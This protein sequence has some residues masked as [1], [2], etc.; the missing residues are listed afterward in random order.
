MKEKLKKISTV[1]KTIFG[2]SMMITLLVGALTFFGYL[3]ALIIGGDIAALICD[4]IYKKVIPA[5]IYI[6]TSTVLFGLLA[7]Y[8]AGEKALTPSNKSKYKK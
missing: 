3:V 2:Y 8:L 1:C 5:M 6:N 7:M 4:I